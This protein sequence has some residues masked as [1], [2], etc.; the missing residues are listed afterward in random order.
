M[1]Y[2]LQGKT[3][4]RLLL[5]EIQEKDY[6]HWLPFFEDPKT[7]AHWIADYDSPEKEC[8]KWYVRQKKRYDLGEGGMNVLIEKDSGLLIG[9]CGLLVQNVDGQEELEIGYSLLPQ[10][11]NKGYATEAARKC[12]DVAFNKQYAASLISIISLPNI[13]SQQVALKNGMKKDTRTTYRNNP[14]HIFRITRSQ[15]GQL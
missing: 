8:Q 4:A 7:T 9:H 15:W 12:R 10:F 13:P 1:R 11:W 3:T 2:L 5:R 14:V 6:V